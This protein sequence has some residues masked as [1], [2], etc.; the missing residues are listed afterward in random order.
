M[1]G[2]KET[3]RNRF[4]NN[5]IVKYLTPQPLVAYSVTNAEAVALKDSDNAWIQERRETAAKD[6]VRSTGSESSMREVQN[7]YSATAP[8]QDQLS[9]NS[10]DDN[11]YPPITLDSARAISAT[12]THEKATF[13]R[14]LGHLMV[15]ATLPETAMAVFE[16]VGLQSAVAWMLHAFR[17]LGVHEKALFAVF[18]FSLSVAVTGLEYL[19]RSVAEL[20]ANSFKLD[21]N[22]QWR[23][24]YYL[25][26]AALEVN[27]D[28]VHFN[29]LP[30]GLAKLDVMVHTPFP[31]I[32]PFTRREALVFTFLIYAMQITN[33]LFSEDPEYQKNNIFAAGLDAFYKNAYFVFFAQMVLAVVADKL[34]FNVLPMTVVGMS[35]G[36]S[37]I[38]SKV[39]S[40]AGFVYA[41]VKGC[42][43]KD[44]EEKGSR[45]AYGTE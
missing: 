26:M 33:G 39:S 13:D 22:N 30:F 43:E 15:N 32:Q 12:V 31:K 24:G 42:C 10:E 35:L 28:Q 17:F 9:T 19:I 40:C 7:D 45:L 41:K 5:P 18:N 16:T 20:D 11:F 23:I 2:R 6:D 21:K 8:E 34:L 37:K 3:L 25:R 27:L 1:R 4:N 36:L 29:K 14:L 44:E 38:G